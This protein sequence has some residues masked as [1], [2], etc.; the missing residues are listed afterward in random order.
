MIIAIACSISLICM[1]KSSDDFQ[2]SDD[3]NK[4]FKMTTDSGLGAKR[5][6]PRKRYAGRKH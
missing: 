4:V 6:L 5:W 2:S 1:D 3:Y